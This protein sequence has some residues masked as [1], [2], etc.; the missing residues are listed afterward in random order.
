MAVSPF[1]RCR[2]GTSSVKVTRLGLGT[3]ALGNLYGALSDRE[4]EGTVAE[5]LRVGIRYIDTAPSYG[6]GIAEERIGRVLRGVERSQWVLSTKV[7]RLLRSGVPQDRG[8]FA[9]GRPIFENV[10][11]ASPVF[12]FS[13]QGTLTSFEESLTRLGVERIDVA[14]IHDPDE[15]FREALEGAYPAL[16][17]LRSEGRISAIGVGMNQAEMLADFVHHTDLDCVLVAGRYTLLEQG[18]LEN[19][20]PLCELHHV[21]LIVGGAYN[22]GVLAN[23]DAT[24][25]DL[26]GGATYNHLAVPTDVW[27]RVRRLK[28]ICE[29]HGVPLKAAAAQ[30]PFGHPAVSSVLMGARSSAQV[31]D[32]L[33]MLVHPIPPDLWAELRAEGLLAPNVPVPEDAQ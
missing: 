30:F 8:H 20:L 5:A 15:H 22:S 18:A 28:S 13:F 14:L 29:R 4:A 2:L 19:L 12:D 9:N 23:P 21:S 3:L 16:E 27:A 32:N 17:R 10:G 1:E 26:A 7:G 6:F 25:S 33:A 31:E 24:P 11:D